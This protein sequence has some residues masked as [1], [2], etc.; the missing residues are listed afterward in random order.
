[1]SVNDDEPAPAPPPAPLSQW[2]STLSLWKESDRITGW[3][4]LTGKEGE[5]EGRNPLPSPSS[6]LGGHDP[7]EMRARRLARS[8]RPPRGRQ[9]ASKGVDP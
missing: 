5:V 7:Q 6:E 3:T 9:G 2:C 8:G 4:G 1:M